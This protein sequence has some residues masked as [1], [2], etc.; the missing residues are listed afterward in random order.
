MREKEM[1]KEDEEW[2]N[3]LKSDL[4]MSLGKYL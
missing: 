4:M 2:S 3:F 1:K